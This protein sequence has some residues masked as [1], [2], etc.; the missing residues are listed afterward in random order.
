MG[1]SCR[2]R[3]TVEE[4]SNQNLGGACRQVAGILQSCG[5]TQAYLQV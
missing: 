4:F 3:K 1:F 5:K 2:L